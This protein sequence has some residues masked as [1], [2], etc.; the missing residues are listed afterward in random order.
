[1]PVQ[2]LTIS[3]I[4]QLKS[5]LDQI[6]ENFEKPVVEQ[7]KISV[8]FVDT[9]V[10]DDLL[11]CLAQLWQYETVSTHSIEIIIK[12]L[13]Y[14]LRKA[15]LRLALKTSDLVDPVFLQNIF[16]LIKG[17]NT[18]EEAYFEHEQVFLNDEVEFLDIFDD[19]ETEIR[20]VTYKIA[21]YYISMLKTCNLVEGVENNPNAVE[22]ENLY[23]YLF[24]SMDVTILAKVLSSIK[25]TSIWETKKIVLN[26][27]G[28]LG[29][30]AEKFVFTNT[31]MDLI[32]SAILERT[33]RNIIS[34][35]VE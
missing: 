32:G 29:K 20:E 21:E 5:I 1:M 31:V 12:N 33:T 4:S 23:V 19:L 11:K 35:K 25:D 24:N 18:F 15:A 3:N 16:C 34:D 28:Y 13:S 10:E 30:I 8:K 14:D 17:Y 27:L 6:R 22:M 26:S 7:N 2:E 9:I